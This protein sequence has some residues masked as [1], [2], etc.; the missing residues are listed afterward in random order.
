VAAAVV[1]LGVVIPAM[2][3]V[4]ANRTTRKVVVAKPRAHRE[5]AQRRLAALFHLRFPC[6]ALTRILPLLPYLQD[7]R[8][9]PVTAQSQKKNHFAVP[10]RI[11]GS[12]VDFRFF[13]SLRRPGISSYVV[14][15]DCIAGYKC[16]LKTKYCLRM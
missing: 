14:Q 2:V 12:A 1:V 3:L 16:G 11:S 13:K 7:P 4:L 5:D 6:T 15:G 10:P 8:S 9:L